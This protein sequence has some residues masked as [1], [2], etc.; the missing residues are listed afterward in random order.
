MPLSALRIRIHSMLK[1]QYPLWIAVSTTAQSPSMPSTYTPTDGSGTSWDPSVWPW[2]IEQYQ[3][4]NSY[5]PG[6][7]DA[8]NPAVSLSTL[9]IGLSAQPVLNVSTTSLTLPAAT[10]G[11]AGATTSFTVGG[12]GLGSGDTLTLVAPSGSE[13]SQNGSS[14]FGS[15]LL[16]NSDASGNVSSTVY[17][18]IS[19]SATANVSGYLTITDAL[20]SSL[21]KS[22]SVSGSVLTDTTLPALAITNPANN[23]TVTSASLLVSGTAS[24]S[25][26]GNNGISSV[27]V[28]GVSAS[29]GTASGSGTANWNATITLSAGANTITV[30]ATDGVGN[31]TQNQVSVTYNSGGGGGGGGGSTS[32]QFTS[33]T[34]PSGTVGQIYNFTFTASG[35]PTPNL[36]ASGAL[37]PGLSL[38]A[39]SGE[40]F[41]SGTPTQAGS[42]TLTAHASNNVGS[43][44][45]VTVTIT[46]NAA[47]PAPAITSPSTASGTYGQ[48]FNPYTITATTNPTSYGATGLPTGLSVD[49][50]TGIISGTPTQTGP[51]N[52]SLSATNSGGTGTAAVLT[53]TIA[54]ATING[55]ITIANKVYDGTT[56][57]TI[58]GRALSG[59]FGADD[60]SLSGGTAAFSD[61]N[62]GT[63]KT[64]TATGLSLNGAS[65]GNYQLSSTSATITA[66]ITAKS[67]T[68][69]GATANNKAYDGTTAATLST[70]GASLSGVV[71]GDS[72]TLSAT[73]ASA[74]FASASA[75]TGKTV[76]ITGLTITGADAGNYI[77]TQPTATADITKATATVTLGSLSQTYTGTPRSA[78]ATT[79]PAGLTVNFTY[80]GSTTVPTNAGSYTAVGTISDSNYAGSMNG[81]LVVGKAPLTAK[82][83]DKRKLQGAANPTLT[84]TYTGFVNGE[85]AAVLATPPTA[86]TTAIATSPAG[87]YPITLTGGSDNNYAFTLQN[88]TLTVTTLAVAP[89]ITSV[90]S[91]TFT[92]G[93]PGSFSVTATGTPAPTF[94]ATGLPA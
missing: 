52:V 29:G 82:A 45:S 93:Q 5:E 28:S 7:L 94:S 76:T 51:F 31:T 36:Y 39:S 54:K 79:S 40:L 80:N 81:A 15:T 59:K 8:L 1:P 84:I 55:S 12:S 90:A 75:G 4:S 68:V 9:V 53:L 48:T 67:L 20:Q 41:L 34:P 23:A 60:V 72:V 46:I 17:A 25:G 14:G 74:S 50:S 35:N 70:A 89:V 92:V 38:I 22:I 64:V 24:D 2:S 19:V 3:T 16:L 37:P 83:D 85:T 77:L 44:A 27:T 30:I 88:G 57:A 69:T 62:V 87:T 91:A 21:N 43:D 33:G 73:G 32:P 78:T 6:D 18:R 10:Q 26:Y 63:G 56:A 61:K 86:S 49:P 58:T 65:A 11:T 47:P 66:N 13:V 71:S 42:Y